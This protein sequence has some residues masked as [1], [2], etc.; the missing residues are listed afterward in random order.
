MI[1]KADCFVY[2]LVMERGGIICMF[3]VDVYFHFGMHHL[4]CVMAVTRLGCVRLKEGRLDTPQAFCR[5]ICW[6]ASSVCCFLP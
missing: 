6:T 1:R 3:P 4:H 5:W 2:I